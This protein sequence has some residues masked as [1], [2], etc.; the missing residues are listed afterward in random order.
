MGASP[1]KT[2][3]TDGIAFNFSG[4]SS[5]L[6][7]WRSRSN[8]AGSRRRL[9]DGGQGLGQQ[10][11]SLKI[12]A[13]MM[14]TSG[15]YASLACRSDGS[16]PGRHAETCVHRDGCC[17]VSKRCPTSPARSTLTEFQFRRGG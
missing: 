6:D 17:Q 14:M 12:M 15:L 5:L 13:S 8:R 16:L 2:C 3:F 9:R 10:L 4:S 11:R 7:R 1:M